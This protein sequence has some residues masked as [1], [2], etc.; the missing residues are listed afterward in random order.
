MG[1]T[2]KISLSLIELETMSNSPS[3]TP[4]HADYS[5]Y[6]QQTSDLLGLNLRDQYRE[7]VSANFRELSAIAQEVMAF[8]LP[9]NTEIAPVFKP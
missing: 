2:V 1:K 6:V 5:A 8:P 9:P 4:P 3:P 7:G